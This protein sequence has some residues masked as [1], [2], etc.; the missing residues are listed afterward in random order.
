M[1]RSSYSSGSLFKRGEIWYL[2]IGSSSSCALGRRR[3]L[4]PSLS[5]HPEPHRS[6][7]V[8]IKDRLPPPRD[9]STQ[10]ESVADAAGASERSSAAAERAEAPRS[11]QHR[12]GIAKWPTNALRHIFASYHLAKWQDAA[13]LALQTGH[14]TTAMLFGHYREVVTPEE[15]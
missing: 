4:N 2:S 11:A 12:A 8:E 10:L 7:S 15:A 14:T 5:G 9:D 3:A 6:D 13:A 1:P